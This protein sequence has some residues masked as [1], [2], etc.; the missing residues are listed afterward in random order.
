M[1]RAVCYDEAVYPAPNTFDPERFLKDGKLDPSVKDPRDR[2]FG[3]GR[4]YDSTPFRPFPEPDTH[5]LL[6]NLPLE[7]ICPGRWFALRTLF[8]N[9]ARTL[10]IFDI[11]APAGE[12]PEP[13]F[14][15]SHI[16]CVVRWSKP[17]GEID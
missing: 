10:T 4:R 15:E 6:F 8:L 13:K 11:E 16:R 7:R 2:I 1:Y 3:T 5:G 9:V 17:L 14:H 12:K